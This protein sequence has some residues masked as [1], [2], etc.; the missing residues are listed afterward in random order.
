MRI[1]PALIKVAVTPVCPPPEACSTWENL[2]PIEN[3]RVGF[4]AL[5]R[6]RRVP[7]GP[8]TGEA[9]SATRT[10]P[11]A[12]PARSSVTTVTKG[13]SPA[14][15]GHSG[16][17][18]QATQ[19]HTAVPP[20]PDGS[21]SSSATVYA[22]GATVQPGGHARVSD[23]RNDW[24]IY[25]SCGV[26]CYARLGSAFLVNTADLLVGQQRIDAARQLPG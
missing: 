26:D 23:G 18:A 16:G 5:T 7:P 19:R 10:T 1:D 12:A 15:G 24:E 22:E 8:G 25:S 3:I 9:D 20:G 17:D 13:F 11:T 2:G 4:P 14:R 21:S 6:R